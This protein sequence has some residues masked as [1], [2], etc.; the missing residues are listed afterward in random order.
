MQEREDVRSPR[1]LTLNIDEVAAH[2]RV[3]STNT[4]RAAIR[5]GDCPPPDL[6]IGRQPRWVRAR[7]EGW[8]RERTAGL[9]Q[10]EPADAGDEAE[11]E[12]AKGAR[13]RNAS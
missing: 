4:V 2:L 9:E 12:E 6:H 10:V 5:R 7:F 1:P 13:G 8:L 3:S 11:L